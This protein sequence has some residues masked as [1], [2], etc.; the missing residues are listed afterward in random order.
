MR[1]HDLLVLSAS[2]VLGAVLLVPPPAIADDVHLTNGNSFEGVVAHFDGDE[3]RI[4]LA[5]GEISL[6]RHRV[7]RIDK[8]ESPLTRFL[9]RK[10]ALGEEA[11]ADQ[12]LTLALWSD[13]YEELRHVTREA[14]LRAARLEPRLE[15]LAPLMQRLGYVWDEDL[16]EW[17]SRGDYLRRRG[18]V[19][20]DGQWITREEYN[21]RRREVELAVAEARERHREERARRVAEAALETAIEARIQAEVARETQRRQPYYASVY[22]PVFSLPLVLGSSFFHHQP[23]PDSSLP[24]PEVQQQQVDPPFQQQ[25]TN[26]DFGGKLGGPVPGKL[27]S[28]T[29][30]P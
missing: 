24:P 9:E 13:K 8:V 17:A 15:E 3:V 12:W 11:T 19:Y 16:E 25:I 26:R 28:G 1:K 22:P 29:S 23:G 5:H 6:P 30:S 4:R 10:A 21:E 2:L 7:L 20:A 27:R 14:A 18:F